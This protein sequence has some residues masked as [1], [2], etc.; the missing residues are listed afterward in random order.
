VTGTPERPAS[1]PGVIVANAAGMEGEA[2][3]VT[4]APRRSKQP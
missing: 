3:A 1:I 4:A 2:P